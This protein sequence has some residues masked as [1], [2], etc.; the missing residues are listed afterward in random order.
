MRLADWVGSDKFLKPC[1]PFF[2]VYNLLFKA[3][4][5][6]CLLTCLTT[7]NSWSCHLP[8]VSTLPVTVTLPGPPSWLGWPTDSQPCQER[9]VHSHRPHFVVYLSDHMQPVAVVPCWLVQLKNW[10]LHHQGTGGGCRL[11]RAKPLTPWLVS[12]GHCC[13]PT[14]PPAGGS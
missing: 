10:N 13:E 12:S 3:N 9:S 2:F 7:S 11:Q 4:L 1:I 14:P 5:A 6:C 8:I